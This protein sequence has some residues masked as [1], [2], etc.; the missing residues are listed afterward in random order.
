MITAHGPSTETSTTTIENPI[1]GVGQG[2]TYALA[3]WILITT[4]LSEMYNRS[5]QGVNLISPNGKIFLQLTHTM[6]VDDAYL[7]HASSNPADTTLQL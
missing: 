4:L 5:T 3:G 7:F 1:L 2:A 6:F